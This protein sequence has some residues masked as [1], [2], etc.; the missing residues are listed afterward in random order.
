[1]DAFV[2]L[3]AS[4]GIGLSLPVLGTFVVAKRYSLLADSLAHVS[5]AGVGLGLLLNSVPIVLAVF[6]AIL[7]AVAIEYL[8]QH[9]R[10]AGDAAM[11]LLMSGGL[12][13]AVVFSGLATGGEVDL[14]GYLFGDVAH[15]S[16]SELPWLI[17]VA[18]LVIGFVVANYR[19]L[20][21]T[22]IDEDGAR[23]AGYTVSYYNYGLVILVAVAAV[24]AM[25]IMGGLLVSALMVV[26]VLAAAR[27]T[28]SFRS[29]LLFAVGIGVGSVIL[30]LGLAVWLGVAP[31]AAIVVAVTSL[32]LA[33]LFLRR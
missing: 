20:M 32:Y 31:G 1:M 26:P 9:G 15:V 13:M 7:G 2:I 24:V 19:G 22:V 3:L 23:V 17:M 28:N 29:T 18:L 8:R 11:A 12:A 4:L 25:R 10:L 16:G 21:H 27:I 30:G 33:M 14:E 6:A 5:L